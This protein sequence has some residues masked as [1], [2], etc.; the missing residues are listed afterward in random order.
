MALMALVYLYE[1]KMRYRKTIADTVAYFAYLR[2][3]KLS[4]EQCAGDTYA[5]RGLC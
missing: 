4:K 5:V 1:S 3:V 2:L